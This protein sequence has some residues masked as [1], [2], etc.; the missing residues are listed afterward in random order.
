ML[1]TEIPHGCGPLK[2][3]AAEQVDEKIKNPERESR[4]KF[5]GLSVSKAT[6]PAIPD[7]A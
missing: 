1:L 7:L 2:R 3:R 4:E 6:Y 5:T